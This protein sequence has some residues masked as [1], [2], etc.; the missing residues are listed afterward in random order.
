MSHKLGQ[1]FPAITA[2]RSGQLPVSDL[3]TMHWE[4]SGLEQ[5]I[6]VLVLHGGPGGSIKDYYRQLLD[7]AR[8]LTICYDQRGCGKS[9]PFAELRDN[10]TS[11]L[12]EDI[13][14]L[15]CHLGIESWWVLGG[16]WGSTLALAYSQAH[17]AAVKGMVVTGVYL[18]TQ[19]DRD[20]WW[21]L[22][23]YVFPDAW[24]YLVEFLPEAE[25]NNV[26]EA[27]LRRVLS[28]DPNVFKPAAMRLMLYEARLLDPKPSAELL[29]AMQQDEEGTVTMARHFCHYDRAGCFLEPNQ[30][31]RDAGT[32]RDIPGRIISG[33]SDMCTPPLSA[34]A[35]RQAWP[36][37]SLSLVPLAGHRWC[38]PA[39]LKEIQRSFE[40][41]VVER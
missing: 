12:V 24:A 29:D 34:W 5:G 27:Y 35:L 33:R 23:R 21:G 37:A 7:P 16:S 30:L 15:R 6:P 41:L 36:E 4:A 11:E 17:P 38:D 9:T 20:W 18:A 28:Q 31:L 2:H 14:T 10:T 22:S 19:E 3:H 25:R 8:F 1:L 40:E 13:E 26:R 32:L 39:L